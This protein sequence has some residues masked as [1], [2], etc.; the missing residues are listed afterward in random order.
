MPSSKWQ[1]TVHYSNWWKILFN[2]I[3][4]GNYCCNATKLS[5]ASF[6]K[7]QQKTVANLLK[8]LKNFVKKFLQFLYGVNTRNVY[9]IS[10]IEKT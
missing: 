4:Q 3:A 2:Y 8:H 5:T 1:L 7:K 9:Q 10:I 6:L